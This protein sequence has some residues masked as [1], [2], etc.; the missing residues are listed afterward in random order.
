MAKAVAFL[1]LAIALILGGTALWVNR[2]AARAAAA[3]P[4][5]GRFLMVDSVRLHYVDAGSAGNGESPLVL[6]HG[7]PGGIQDFER[8]IPLLATSHRV[9]AVDRPGHGYSERADLR[10]ATPT[11]QATQLH[12]GLDQ[13]GVRRPILVGHSWGGALALAYATEFPDDV[14]GLVLLGTRAYP[15]EGPPD[16]LYALLRRPVI[17]PVLR[18]TLVPVLGRGTLDARMSAAYLPDGVQAGHLASAR[19]LWMRP[20]QLGA[21][22]WDTFLLQNDAGMMA[23]KYSTVAVPVMI[24][25]GDQDALLPESRQLANQLPNAWIEVL[26]NTGHYLPRTRVAEIQRSVD[27]LEARMR[28]GATSVT[29]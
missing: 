5:A 19:A 8:L 23:R 15:V 29:R 10:G 9:I 18:H 1:A 11:A 7:N 26:R 22:V 20:S 17:G 24:L 28:A 12:T 4:P 21:T 25:A 13:L 3:Y 27:V 6:I 2:L 16:P 14:A